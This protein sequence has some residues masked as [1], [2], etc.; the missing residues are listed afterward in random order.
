MQIFGAVHAG[1]VWDRAMDGFM[2]GMYVFEFWPLIF[3]VYV[4][5][6]RTWA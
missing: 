3:T 1:I 4:Y 6:I 5:T 2:E